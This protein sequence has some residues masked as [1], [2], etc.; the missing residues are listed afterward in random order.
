MNEP[1][2]KRDCGHDRLHERER[3]REPE[4]D[5]HREHERERDGEADSRPAKHRCEAGNVTTA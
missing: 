3:G 1:D 4:R 2:R 5:R